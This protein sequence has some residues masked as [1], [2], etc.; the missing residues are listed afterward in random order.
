[1]INEVI[2]NGNKK[3][4]LF[5][6]GASRKKFESLFKIETFQNNFDVIEI[7]CNFENITLNEIIS[8]I[9][10]ELNDTIK[11]YSQVYAICKSLG[12]VISLLT[13]I[14]FKT[15]FFLASPVIIGESSILNVGNTDI[16]KLELEEI[17]FDK[18]DLENKEIIIFQGTNDHEKFKKIS[19]SLSNNLNTDII[20]MNTN[21]SFDNVKEELEKKILQIV[22]H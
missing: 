11:N 10:L 1:M 3:A 13:N 18:R 5:F 19:K 2:I 8:E 12:G 7:I 6:S 22:R 20:Y 14:N 16:E 21:H 9:H 17:S 4:I 15:Y